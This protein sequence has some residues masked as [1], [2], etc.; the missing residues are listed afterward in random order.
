MSDALMAVYN[1]APIEVD[2]GEGAWLFD[3][4]GKSWLDCMCGIATDALGH[5]TPPWSR[6]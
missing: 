4:H 5:P 6:R 2:H 3:V 1:R